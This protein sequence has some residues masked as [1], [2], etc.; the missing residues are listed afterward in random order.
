MET[1]R[2]QW[3]HGF[4]G[5]GQN[6]FGAGLYNDHHFHW[7]YFIYAAAAIGRKNSAWLTEHEVGR[8]HPWQAV[9]FP[10]IQSHL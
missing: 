8:C 4:A 10:T 2:F 5:P 7:G 1:R 6:D 3:N 9:R